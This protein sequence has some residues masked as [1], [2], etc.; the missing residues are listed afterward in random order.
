MGPGVSSA[1]RNAATAARG[2]SEGPHATMAKPQSVDK[3]LRR[4]EYNRAK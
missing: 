1:T 3:A 4:G 2:D